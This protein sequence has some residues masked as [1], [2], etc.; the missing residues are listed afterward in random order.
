MVASFFD[1]K[2][3]AEK[4]TTYVFK[5]KIENY[6]FGSFIRLKIN[7]RNENKIAKQTTL[8]PKLLNLKKLNKT[9]ILFAGQFLLKCFCR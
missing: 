7:F 8:F 9:Q 2:F 1:G 6:G 3:T 4:K 5:R